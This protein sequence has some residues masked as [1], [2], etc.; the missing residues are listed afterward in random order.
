M[1]LN[2]NALISQ[3]ISLPNNEFS[4]RLKNSLSRL[5]VWWELYL[6]NY[7]TR[8]Q[9]RFINDALLRDIGI[10]RKQAAAESEK[11]FWEK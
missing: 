6:R 1:K 11:Y 3:T 4:W 9:L 2:H 7:R 10:T 8:R 5:L